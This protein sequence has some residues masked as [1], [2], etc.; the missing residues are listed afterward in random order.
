MLGRAGGRERSG[1]GEK[2]HLAALEEIVG[3][4]LLRAVLRHLH[5]SGAGQPVAF[6]VRPLVFRHARR[7][8]VSP[9][10]NRLALSTGSGPISE[11]RRVGNC[12]SVRVDNG[13]RRYVKKQQ[14][15][16]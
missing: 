7:E 16:T 15:R 9:S 13:G 2:R 14:N 6:A 10:T 12:V 4:H 3:L 1:N 5:K 8:S 11:E